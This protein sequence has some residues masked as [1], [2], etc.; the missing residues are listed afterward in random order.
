M[1][2]PGGSVSKESPCIAGD[3][4]LIPGWGRSPVEGNGNPLQYSSLG[5]PVDRRA[6]QDTVHGM[7]KSRTQFSN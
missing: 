3:L 6:W 7:A 5:D 2:F 4:G 1:G